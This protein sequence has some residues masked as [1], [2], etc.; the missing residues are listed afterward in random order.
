MPT[1]IAVAVVER[2]GEFLVGQRPPGVP[3][4][5]LWE[6]PGGKVEPGEAP[7]D[8]AVRECLEEAGVT[9]TVAAAYG[10]HDQQYDHGRVRLHF[11]AC[12]PNS[13]SA[14]PRAPFR[15]VGRAELAQLEFPVGNR[16]LVR[17]LLAG[18][19]WDRGDRGEES[20]LKRQDR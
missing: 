5:G 7:E 1:T 8:A 3:L 12:R 13:E 18:E 15:W 17:R 20:G 2:N 11:F 4:A 9:I 10:D 19:E 14:T 16:A 6:F